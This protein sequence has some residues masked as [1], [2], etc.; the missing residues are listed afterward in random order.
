MVVDHEGGG[1]GGGHGHGGGYGGSGAASRSSTLLTWVSISIAAEATLVLAAAAMLVMKK[2]RLQV[3]G[4]EGFDVAANDPS[5]VLISFFT[6]AD[7]RTR[8][9]TDVRGWIR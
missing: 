2:A 6:A 1:G 8:T 5:N 9:V 7:S 3:I 4:R